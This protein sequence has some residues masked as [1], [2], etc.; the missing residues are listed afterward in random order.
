[1][2]DSTG[3]SDDTEAIGAIDSHGD[4][5]RWHGG[6]AGTGKGSKCS[7]IRRCVGFWGG[8]NGWHW[9]GCLNRTL[10]TVAALA[11]LHGRSG[12]ACLCHWCQ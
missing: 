8:L 9:Q 4:R 7:Y 6:T 5:T 2:P 11:R 3:R 1:M 10:T 12:V